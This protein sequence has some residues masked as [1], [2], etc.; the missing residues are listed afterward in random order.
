MKAV[1]LDVV[2]LAVKF[3]RGT[4]VFGL[5][6]SKT[7]MTFPCITVYAMC[8]EGLVLILLS[9]LALM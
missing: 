9:N 4:G 8:M 7:C 1:H 5:G 6:T 3:E 2:G